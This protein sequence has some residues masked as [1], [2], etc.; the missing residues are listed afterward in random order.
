MFLYYIKEMDLMLP[1]LLSNRSELVWS[2]ALCATILFLPHFDVDFDLILNIC[3]EI[4]TKLVVIGL[5]VTRK[6]VLFSLF[7]A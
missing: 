1:Y 4:E 5:Y 7:F 6:G 3:T 2:I